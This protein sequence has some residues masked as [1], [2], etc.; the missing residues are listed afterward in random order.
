MTDQYRE[1]ERETEAAR[2]GVTPIVRRRSAIALDGI[3]DSFHHINQRQPEMPAGDGDS[4][5]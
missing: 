2:R 1:I 4:K 5:R 3:T